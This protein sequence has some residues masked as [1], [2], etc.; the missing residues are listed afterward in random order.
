[1]KYI[2]VL[3]DG[4]SD[5]PIPELGDITPLQAAKTP[6]M[7]FIARH[8]VIGLVKTIP[9]N[10]SPGSDTANLSVMGFNPE[11]YY[12]GRSPIEAVSMGVVLGEEDIA[13]RCNLVTLS[14]EEAY[15]EKTMVDYSSDEIPSE[16]AAGLIK[17]VNEWLLAG[18][19]G[20]AGGATTGNPE[21]GLQGD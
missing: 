7:D 11:D 21:G 16:E 18:M 3:G 15:E 20:K 6:G 12:T 4:M 1:M 9:E 10:V 14:D 5:Y 17:S 13:Y 8:G 19:P 2:V